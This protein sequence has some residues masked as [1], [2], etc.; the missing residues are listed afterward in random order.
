MR[1]R[2]LKPE[3][4][5]DRKMGKLGAVPALVY[6]SLWCSADDG[7]V[8]LCAPEVIK[9]E[10]FMYWPSIDLPEISNA[11]EQLAVEKRIERYTV[12][13]DEYC[14]IVN[15]DKHQAVH[16]PSLFRHPR[17]LQRVTESEDD[18]LRHLPGTSS[19]NGR[20]PHILDTQT[21]RLL[22]TYSPEFLE[23]RKVYPKR[24]GGDSAADAWKQWQARLRS[25]ETSEV[26]HTG[27]LRYKA[28]CDA[29]GKTNTEY[30]KQMCTFLGK[31]RHYLEPWDIPAKRDRHLSQEEEHR[32]R[33]WIT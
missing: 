18:G 1:A 30:V 7:G 14:L 10:M 29:M 8:A 24:A 15:F 21:P 11:L 20:T 9:G 25:G 26:I 19:E 12:G 3:F 32:K 23:T 2:W 17:P 28:Y 6:Q 22:N 4:F 5:K 16:K 31:S 13:D 33:G 27:V